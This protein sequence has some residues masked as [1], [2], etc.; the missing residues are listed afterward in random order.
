MNVSFWIDISGKQC[1]HDQTALS[2]AYSVHQSSVCIFVG[3]TLA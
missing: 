3:I 1:R 2:R